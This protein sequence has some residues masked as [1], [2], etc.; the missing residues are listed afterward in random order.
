MTLSTLVNYVYANLVY[1]TSE[2]NYD[3]RFGCKKKQTTL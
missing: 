2:D 1:I 3:K